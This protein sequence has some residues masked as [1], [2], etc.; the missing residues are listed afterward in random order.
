MKI[1]G[2]IKDNNWYVTDVKVKVNT[3]TDDRSGVKS[4]GIGSTT[5][6]HSI[7]HNTDGTKLQYTGY[8]EDKAGN[9]NTCKTEKF[10]RDATKPSCEI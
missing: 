9:V 10:K 4:Y 7:T 2:T 3:H 8:I 5:G 1:T 6:D